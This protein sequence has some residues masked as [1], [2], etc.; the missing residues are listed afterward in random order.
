MGTVVGYTAI[1]RYWLCYVVAGDVAISSH[2]VVVGVDYSS[3]VSDYYPG[4]WSSGDTGGDDSVIAP[5]VA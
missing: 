1:D 3:G 4:D 2:Y 5:D